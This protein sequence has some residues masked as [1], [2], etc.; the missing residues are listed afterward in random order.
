[1]GA[2]FGLPVR[3]YP[4]IDLPVV[5]INTTFPGASAAV[6]ES[7]VSK[8]IE[9]AIS[10]IEGVRTITTV[11]NDENSRIDVEFNIARNIEFA[12]ADVRDQLG[13]IRKQLP[14]GI[15]DPVIIKASSSSS[16][17]LW[18]AMQDP[19][20]NGLELTD[21]A[22]RNLI[23]SL[24]V[25]PGV[26]RVQIGG[27]RRSAM[28]IW[29]DPDA[30][31]A[32]GI[33]PADVVARLNQENLELPSGRLESMQRE[34]SVRTT[35]RLS[36]PEEFQALVLREGGAGSSAHAGRVL[37]GDVARIERGAA[38]Y[39]T[40]LWIDGKP[41]IGLG[42]VKQ[43]TAN[44][45]DVADGVRAAIKRLGPS[46][47]PGLTLAYPYD[48]SLFIK[49]SI[50]EVVKT[51]AIALGL[52]VI[53]ILVFLRS[54]VAMLI[55]VMAIPV[56]LMAAAMVMAALGFSINVLTLLAMVLA[57]GLVVDDA[58]VVLENVYR[59]F[60]QGEPRLLAGITGSRE[61]GFAVI[62]TTTV[63]IS[64]FVPIS[65]QSG[66]VGRLQREFG[67]TLAATVAFSAFVALTLAPMMC[68]KL[69]RRAEHEGVVARVLGRALA[70]LEAGYAWLLERTMRVRPLVALIG[71]VV[72]AAAG[73][74]YHVTQQDLSP[75]EDQGYVII[76]LETPQGTT[77]DGT[78][79]QVDHVLA[80]VEPYKE[81][82]GGPV[83]SLLTIIPAFGSPGTVNSAFIIARLRPWDE[84][85]MSQQDLVKKL[86][87]GLLTGLPG[88][89]AFAINRPSFGLRDF[90][91]S[92]SIVLEGENYE[93]VQGWIR[94]LLAKARQDPHFT[95]L[96]D[97]VDLT[98]PQLL[99][100]VDRAR[101][102]ELG[103]TAQDI[104]TALGA[105][106]GEMKV[107]TYQDRG[108]QY[109]V[110]LQASKGE[111]ASAEVLQRIHARAHP[112]NRLVP[113]TTIATATEAGAP[114]ELRRIDRRPA[115]IISA[116]LKGYSMGQALAVLEGI[117]RTELPP[118]AHLAF[119][120]QAK[121]YKDAIGESFTILGIAIPMQLMIFGLAGLIVFLV[122][123]AQFE[124][125]IHP[126]II[127]VG[128]PLAAAGGLAALKLTGQTLNVYSQIGLIMLIGL[129][130]KNGILMV[131]FA[132]QL[133][134]RGEEIMP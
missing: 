57:I 76:P 50:R 84:R 77:M 26:S 32:H 108:E 60:E 86:M 38:N 95:G 102:A 69:L 58:I 45:L 99:V 106:L 35:T 93:Q 63:L 72:V 104:G 89:R 42:I 25:V 11:S 40:G 79:A 111:R 110:V 71:V 65:F 75:T 49:A 5:S 125:W 9:E 97:D 90:G 13:R 123:A 109:D 68:T 124:S 46:L 88:A 134:D 73:W 121:E 55:P 28:R 15:D 12:T 113:L 70:G 3:Q 7:D 92:M 94:T 81:A 78:L 66:T 105:V 17:V 20:R 19:A 103:I 61:V 23:D 4:D 18:V 53:V 91:Q 37:L 112:S 8:R 87:G 96:R 33:A 67:L 56:S 41:T 107:T 115:V 24:S 14:T 48:E 129:V 116:T 83:R 100:S 119:T 62:A 22:R 126:L 1:L 114:K 10:G 52:V 80:M 122:L 118:T 39:R 29:L 16:P 82:N 127:I 54:W 51:L 98:R 44:T 21:Y 132:N 6:M 85:T 131:E 59:R 64:V 34:M 133:R 31:A 43:S 128:V 27:E 74:L 36:S 101:A 47:P 120:G 130:A 117:A 2:L 30:M